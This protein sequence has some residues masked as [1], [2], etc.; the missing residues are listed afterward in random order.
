MLQ[1][2]Q[3]ELR[4][5]IHDRFVILLVLIFA[6]SAYALLIGNLYRGEIVQNIPAAVCDLDDSAL[7]REL[8]RDVADADQYDF[9]GVL[10]DEVSAV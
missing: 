5:L 8:I 4:L 1:I 6:A 7:S 2:I 10:T 9:R 3:R